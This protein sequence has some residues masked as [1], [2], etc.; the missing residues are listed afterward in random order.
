MTYDNVCG[1]WDRLAFFNCVWQ[2]PRQPQDCS[3]RVSA[4]AIPCYDT[5]CI[6]MN[7]VQFHNHASQLLAALPRPVLKRWQVMWPNHN[8]KTGRGC[9][10]ESQVFYHSC[11]IKP[12]YLTF[13][14][15]LTRITPCIS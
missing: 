9:G 15:N 8:T 10:Q 13:D 2:P 3:N 5:T 6:V 11:Q 7:V 14:N 1:L 12:D 4:I